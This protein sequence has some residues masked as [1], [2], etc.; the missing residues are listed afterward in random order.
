M[1]SVMSCDAAM[2]VV[3]EASVC[4]SGSGSVIVSG[5]GGGGVGFPAC[6]RN[7]D[8]STEFQQQPACD[9]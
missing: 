3:L 4:D 9:T 1:A 6:V 2:S 8:F 7:S 5:V